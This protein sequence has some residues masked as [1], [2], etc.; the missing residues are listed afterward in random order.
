MIIGA[1]LINTNFV[2]MVQAEIKNGSE[3]WLF[4]L[5]VTKATYSSSV[6]PI[7]MAIWVMSYVELEPIVNKIVPK[8]IR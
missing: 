5:S 8:V 7:L 4:R 1:M 2:Q 6:V 3:T